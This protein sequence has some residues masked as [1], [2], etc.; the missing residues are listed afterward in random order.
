MAK[1]NSIKKQLMKVV[2][3]RS[4]KQS[5]G[6]C[7]EATK[8]TSVPKSVMSDCSGSTV[9]SSSSSRVTFQNYVNVRSTLHIKNMTSSE[10]AR[11]WYNTKEL[12]K[13]YEKSEKE[14]M[15]PLAKERLL[16]RGL[17]ANTT[18]GKE[19]RRRNID[20]S[21]LLVMKEQGFQSMTGDCNPD[22]IRRAYLQI[23]SKC[24]SAARRLG[25]EDERFVNHMNQSRRRGEKSI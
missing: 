1:R 3:P 17:E 16:L 15:I 7:R 10:V 20:N 4:A 24:Q 13:I 18:V 5:N 9:L 11:T 12:D 25:M 23:S 14:M 6:P 2:G 22:A 21:R 8:R 19:Q